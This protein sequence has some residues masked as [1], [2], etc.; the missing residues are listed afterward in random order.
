[1]FVSVVEFGFRLHEKHRRYS[2][3]NQQIEVIDPPIPQMEEILLEKPQRA[4]DDSNAMTEAVMCL[5]SLEENLKRN[6]VRYEFGKFCLIF[7][8]FLSRV[9]FRS[10]RQNLIY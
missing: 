9:G 8:F 2:V 4:I 3:T 5:Q 7:L 10:I 1:M 6:K